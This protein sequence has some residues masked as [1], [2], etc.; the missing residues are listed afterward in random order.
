M[1]GAFQASAFQDNA[2]QVFREIASTAV[3][4]LP[5]DCVMAGDQPI[6]DRYREW[7]VPQAVRTE[8][9]SVMRSRVGRL[10]VRSLGRGALRNT[11]NE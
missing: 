9:K 2:Y 4:Q 1:A 8:R 7:S 3:L 5:V 6:I 10:D 11:F